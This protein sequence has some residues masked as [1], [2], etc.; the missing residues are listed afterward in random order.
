[1]IKYYDDV[2]GDNDEPVKPD[3]VIQVTVFHVGEN[4]TVIT[5]LSRDT[6]YD[7]IEEHDAYS[8]LF[9]GENDD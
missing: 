1:M 2:D 6:M 9:L 8:T 4:K 7:L 3:E 5:H